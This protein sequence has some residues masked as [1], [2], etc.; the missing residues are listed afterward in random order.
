[1]KTMK[2]LMMLAILAFAPTAM[3]AADHIVFI[4]GWQMFSWGKPHTWD[5]MVD[6]MTNK[7]Y[8]VPYTT[9]DKILVADYK[10][11][12]GNATIKRI[13]VKV[14]GQINKRFNDGEKLPKMDFVVHSMGG[15]VLRS[16]VHQGLLDESLIDHVVTLASPH[17]GQS[18]NKSRQ[19][20]CMEFGSQFIWE[21][22]NTSTKIAANKVLCVVATSDDVVDEW[23]AALNDCFAVRYVDKTHTTG[24]EGICKCSGGR[25]DPVYRMVTEFLSSGS[26]STGSLT[27][28]KNYGAILF[29]V[30]DGR[31]NPVAYE[32]KYKSSSSFV[33]QINDETGA[34]TYYRA[35][36][37]AE[38]FGTGVGSVAVLPDVYKGLKPGSYTLDFQESKDKTFTAFTSDPIPV[39]RGRTTVIPIPAEN[40]R[41]LDYVFLIDTTGSMGSHI[42]SV[43]AN[44]KNLIE[45]QLLNGARNSR[46]AVVDYRDFPERTGDSRDY[47]YDVKCKFTS[48]A[49]TAIAAINSLTLG[50]GGDG[51][52]TV[53]SGI[54]ACIVGK[55][56]KIGGWQENSVKTIM[57]MGDAEPLDPEPITGYTKSDVV[58][59]ANEFKTDEDDE[60]IDIEYRLKASNVKAV[61]TASVKAADVVAGASAGGISIYPVVTSSSLVSSFS[62]I[63]EETGGKVVSSTSYASVADAVKEVIEQSVAAN[64]FEFEAV[65]VAETAGSVKVRVFGGSE[66]N[67]A[68]IGYQVVSGSAV[69]GKDF[70]VS[71]GE[72]RLSWSEGERSY[73]EIVI[74]ISE[75]SV[76][77]LDKF[78]SIVLCNPVNMGLGGINVCRVNLTNVHSSEVTPTGDVYIQGI[79]RQPEMGTVI[80]SGYYKTDETATL[81]AN[82]KP[83]FVFTSWENGTTMMRRGIKVSE[84]ASDAKDD[85]ATYVASFVALKD[86]P[87]P[88]VALSD[89]VAGV[90]GEPI[91]WSLDYYSISEAEV[92]CTGLPPGL[93]LVDGV[94]SGTPECFGNWTTT[95]TVTNAKGAVSTKVEFLITPS[96]V[97]AGSAPGDSACEYNGCLVDDDGAL[98]GTIQ[99]K[100]GKP[101]AKT[102]IA[103]VKGTVV[104]VGGK[105][106]TIKANGNGKAKIETTGP[107]TLPFAGGEACSVTLGAKGMSGSYGAWTIDGVRNLLASKDKAEKAAA[108]AAFAPLK[109]TLNIV[110]DGGVAALTVA[111]KGKAKVKGTLA[112]GGKLNA[113][114]QLLVGEKWACVPVAVAKSGL[115][116]T[117]WISLGSG[118]RSYHVVGLGDDVAVGKAGSLPAN[119]KF[120]MDPDD[121]TARWGAVL[122][123]AYVKYLPDGMSVKPNG[124]KWE[125]AKAG[126]IT[127][128]KGV[129]DTSKAGEN[130]SGLKL[131]YKAKDGSFKGSFKIYAEVNGRL[132]ATTVNVSGVMVGNAACGT[133]TVKNLGS[134]G[135]TIE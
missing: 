92:T 25:A 53:Y 126:K 35:Y 2:K 114:A 43:K 95:F 82:A 16:M 63:A 76:S 88:T 128:K 90:S 1:M 120:T 85:V 51:P 121:A 56:A 79:T 8:G 64:G 125:I 73:K 86:L 39:V 27:G 127:M 115:T 84:A 110:W 9:Q 107:T 12:S 71:A 21:L 24:G 61:K 57:V 17:Y 108:E 40:V 28:K 94:V 14:W 15:L 60:A 104:P 48:D 99:V 31:N 50:Y 112:T 109:T 20:K 38:S 117:V 122:G 41:P 37:P 58:R 103:S 74:P 34:K 131:T 135:V 62:E 97:V 47:A 123:A 22:A 4:H 29:Q 96:N 81:T 98:K 45:S 78:F 18:W 3:F 42:N 113:S 77:S 49:A 80:G 111:N 46:V 70:A 65:S 55:G 134:V 67:S 26:V 44:A 132:K 89:V 19:Q 130:P 93:T 133:A 5:D 129:V 33:N 116:F 7:T 101:N 83:G 72:Q 68:S 69:A 11:M 75:D 59:W 118:S 124:T 91:Y 119:A 52:E 10:E 106:T 6:C 87:L 36:S 54:H 105:K 13:A 23:S 102:G 32:C 100:V 66:S 30:V